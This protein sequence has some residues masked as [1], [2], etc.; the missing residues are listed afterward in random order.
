[1]EH[2]GYGN[3]FIALGLV[4]RDVMIMTMNH[5]MIDAFSFRSRTI[6]F[7]ARFCQCS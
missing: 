6:T 3:T 1:M 5:G 2:K 7:E 4:A